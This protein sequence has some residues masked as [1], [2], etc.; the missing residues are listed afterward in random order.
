MIAVFVTTANV[1]VGPGA[2]GGLRV[3]ERLV[4]RRARRLDLLE[5]GPSA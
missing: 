1:D 2:D 4:E 5:Q 3:G